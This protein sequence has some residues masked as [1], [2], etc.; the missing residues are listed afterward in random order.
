MCGEGV[1]SGNSNI[2]REAHTLALSLNGL[3]L[4]IP[5]REVNACL[6]FMCYS[7]ERDA[8]DSDAKAVLPTYSALA[9]DF[10]RSRLLSTTGTEMLSL[11]EAA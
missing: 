8:L 7:L 3:A 6:I 9:G 4:L 10:A 11:I 2:L 5:L 1:A